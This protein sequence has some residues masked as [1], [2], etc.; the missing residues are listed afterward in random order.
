VGNNSN[1]NGSTYKKDYLLINGKQPTFSEFYDY[2]YGG[3]L[4]DLQ[5]EEFFKNNKGKWV[6]FEFYIK[7]AKD[8]SLGYDI[9]GLRNP[10]NQYSG[11]IRNE[12]GVSVSSSEIKKLV[13]YYTGD[14]IMI[15]G[16][17]KDFGNLVGSKIIY[18][19]NAGI[20]GDLTDIEKIQ[21]IFY[22]AT[23]Y[24]SE[25]YCENGYLN[26]AGKEYCKLLYATTHSDEV[27]I[28]MNLKEPLSAMKRYTIP[29]GV[30]ALNLYIDLN[31]STKD[32][33]IITI[34]INKKK[35]DYCNLIDSEI[36]SANCLKVIDNLNSK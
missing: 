8:N 33:C 3:R 25:I 20:F 21:L 5:R 12:I 28:C 31:L 24:N 15:E 16:Q 32:A 17:L 14:K 27:S 10:L 19:N 36:A 26:N 22:N 2:F 9:L 7:S 18:V 4:T 11:I 34:S 35:P 30:E 1:T 23:L 6:F 13:E 29:K